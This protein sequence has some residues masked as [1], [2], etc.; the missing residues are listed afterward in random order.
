MIVVSEGSLLR[1][2]FLWLCLLP[3]DEDDDRLLSTTVL[4]FGR[5]LRCDES[6]G[7]EMRSGC[8]SGTSSAAGPMRLSSTGKKKR[9]LI[10]P[11]IMTAKSSQKM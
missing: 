4:L 9:P 2:T 3:R 8:S 11:M 5:L 6:V 7:V 1:F 10:R